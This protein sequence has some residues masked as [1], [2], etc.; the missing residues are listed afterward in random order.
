MLI[1]Q[2]GRDI[3]DRLV[4]TL[5]SLALPAGSCFPG[6][7]ESIA[8]TS[9]QDRA[10][11]VECKT[12]RFSLVGTGAPGHTPRHGRLLGSRSEVLWL[13]DLSHLRL[14]IPHL[15]LYTLPH[16]LAYVTLQ[17]VVH[18]LRPALLHSYHLL[19][20]LLVVCHQLPVLLFKHD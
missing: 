16:F 5:H 2:R 17:A 13:D 14:F 7:D 3:K 6:L 8:P 10:I 4:Q 12:R 15:P 1:I 20:V 11:A 19:D 9:V 18:E